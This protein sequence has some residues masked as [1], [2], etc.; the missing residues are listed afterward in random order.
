MYLSKRSTIQYSIPLL[1]ES[2]S[3][4]IL[5]NVYIYHSVNVY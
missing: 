5:V 2:K 1:I 4:P 3:Y